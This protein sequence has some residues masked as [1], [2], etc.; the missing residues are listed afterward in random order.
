VTTPS[1]VGIGVPTHNGE[2]YLREA[3]LALLAQDHRELDIVVSDNASTDRTPEIVREIMRRDSRV[4][5][6]RVE[7]LLPATA[8]FNRAFALTTSRFFMWAADDDLWDPTYVRRCLTALEADPAAVMASSSLRFI[9]PA[10]EILDSNYARYDNPDLASR[11]VVERVKI[12]LRRGGFYQVYGLAR[13][14]ALER[15]HLF[16]DVYGPDVVLTL[17]LAILGP[18][19]RIPEPLFFYRRFPDR[20]EEVRTERQGG[21]PGVGGLLTTRMTHLQELLSEAVSA[22]AL[23]ARQ[24]VR[25]RAEILR[26]AYVED[27]PMRSRTR[28]EIASR[29]AGAWHDREPRGLVKFG[30]AWSIDRTK[31]APEAVRRWASRTRRLTGR[32][33]RL[34]ARARRRLP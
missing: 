6:E 8:N 26:A 13:R 4:R 29:V 32:A 7:D 25:L 10:G 19:L 30:L 9:D 34:A 27:T 17:E 22:S 33:R 16:Q 14:E 21:I 5:Y 23:P 18:I 1:L 12:L 31:A 2:P 15:T 28:R 3:L 11:S 24:K 20:T